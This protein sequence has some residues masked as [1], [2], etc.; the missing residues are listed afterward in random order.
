[1]KSTV[2]EFSIPCIDAASIEKIAE[3]LSQSAAELE[4]MCF[5]FRKDPNS[6]HSE[7]DIDLKITE[8]NEIN[9]ELQVHSWSR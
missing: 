5:R 3:K 4:D 9:E 2:Y 8:I 6:P 7:A 1:M